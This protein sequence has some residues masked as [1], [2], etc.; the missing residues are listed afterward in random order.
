MLREH[1]SDNYTRLVKKGLLGFGIELDWVQWG[2]EYSEVG[3]PNYI[4]LKKIEAER[5]KLQ[6][7]TKKRSFQE[8]NDEQGKTNHH[9]QGPQQKQAKV[10]RE[11]EQEHTASNQNKAANNDGCPHYSSI[12]IKFKPYM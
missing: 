4:Y 1:L 9:K 10:E 3:T 2:I 11:K 8:S 12:R 5:S 7:N 6:N